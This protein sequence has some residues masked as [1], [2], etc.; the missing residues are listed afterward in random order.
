MFTIF[1]ELEKSMSQIR[2]FE[3]YFFH[4]TSIPV[5]CIWMSEF[6]LGIGCKPEIFH[7]ALY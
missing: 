1:L 6:E 4:F 5:V 2:G 3:L 7:E